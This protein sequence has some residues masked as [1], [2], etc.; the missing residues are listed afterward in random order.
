MI[1]FNVL[2]VAI[3]LDLAFA[4]VASFA[5]FVNVLVVFNAL[6]VLL[7]LVLLLNVLHLL[8]LIDSIL[9]EVGGFQIQLIVI[10]S[11]NEKLTLFVGQVLF[12][13]HAGIFQDSN[14]PLKLFDLVQVVDERV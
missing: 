6:V 1:I 7:D 13:H 5:F 4:L 8:L 2:A 3:F 10:L 12:R 9:G 11:R 14:I